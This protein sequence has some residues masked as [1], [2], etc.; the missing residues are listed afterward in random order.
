MSEE[1]IKGF[2]D[3]DIFVGTNVEIHPGCDLWMQGARFGIVTSIKDGVAVVRME[4][5]NVR[6]SQRF[7][8]EYLQQ[9]YRKK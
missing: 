1:S 7:K 2:D 3:S 9:R 4:N 8:G 5:K 6:K